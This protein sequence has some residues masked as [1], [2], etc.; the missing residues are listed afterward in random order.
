MAPS[1]L[2]ACLN[3]MD[4]T[5]TLAVGDLAPVGLGLA[6]VV[7]SVIQLRRPTFSGGAA[8]LVL[9]LGALGAMLLGA[10]LGFG[11]RLSA[12]GLSAIPLFVVLV[13][14][15]GLRG[16]FARDLLRRQQVVEARFADELAA[17]RRRAGKDRETHAA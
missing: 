2:V 3:A 17:A 8:A 15:L 7:A 12:F 5:R 16:R 6:F 13:G 1:L 14:W 9:I 11:F 4:G 10:A